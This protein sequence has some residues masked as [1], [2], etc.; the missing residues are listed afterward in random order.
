MTIAD[1]LSYSTALLKQNNIKD[2]R[3]NAELILSEVIKYDRMNLYLNFEKPLSQEESSG[4]EAMLQRRLKN[5]PL[6]YI[7]GKAHFYGMQFFVSQDVLIPRQETELL[8]ERILDDI[9][10]RNAPLKLFEIGTG[11]GCI[12]ISI[13][14]MLE[15][16]NID[17]EIFAIDNSKEAV[18]V[19]VR[20]SKLLLGE[21]S[22]V[23]FHVKDV[24]EID[25]LTKSFDYIISNPPYISLKDFKGLDPEVNEFE[26]MN[27]LTDNGDGL[28]FYKRIFLI[29]SDVSFK[30]KVFCEIGYGQKLELEKILNE[31]NFSNYKFYQDYGNI[32]RI[33]EIKK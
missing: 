11:S 26:P 28:K 1:A 13:A 19:A 7:F 17:Y 32:D 20:N 27:A 15:K 21:N 12:S 3:L 18:N 25:R 2:A 31:K 8:V 16:E 29:A 5:E 9:K 23:K 24:F 6:Q 4:F 14:A 30:G 33:L 22:R 10:K